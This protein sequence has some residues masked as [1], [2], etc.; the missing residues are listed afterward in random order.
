MDEKKVNALWRKYYAARVRET[1]EYWKKY[2]LACL[3]A[4]VFPPIGKYETF[5][6]FVEALKDNMFETEKEECE[7]GNV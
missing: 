1:P 2:M 3:R 4:N 6:D 5:I 7:N